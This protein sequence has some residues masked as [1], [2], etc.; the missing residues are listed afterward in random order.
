MNKQISNRQLVVRI[1]LSLLAGSIITG[2][3]FSIY[4]KNMA[5][6]NLAQEDAK[7]TSNLIFEVMRTKMQEGWG[8]E[9]LVKIMKR[10]NTMKDGL[11]IN[12]YRSSK[13]VELFGE[14]TQTTQ[15]LKSDKNIVKAMN[16]KEVLVVGDDDSIHFYYPM[17]VETECITCHYNTKEGDINGVL[18]IYFPADEI[19]IPLYAMI[20]YFILFLVI[21]LIV[22]FVVFYFILNNKI[23]LPLINFTNQLKDISNIKDMDSRIIVKTQITEIS[24]LGN[25]FNNLLDKIKYYYEKLIYQFFIDQM[26]SLPNLLALK[27]DIRE[28]NNPTLILININQFKN[29]NN[30][31]GYE[32]ED[33]ILKEFS[34][35]LAKNKS[36]SKKSYRISGDEFAWLLDEELNLFDFLETLEEFQNHP[37]EY[38]ESVIYLNISCGVAQ[39]KDRLIENATTALNQAK[40]KTKPF[41]LYDNSMQQESKINDTIYWTKKLKDALEEDRI[42]LYY[43][44]ILDVKLEKATKFE[45]LVRLK[46]KD[47]TIHSPDDFMEAAKLSRLYLR[48]TR[49]IIKQAFKYFKDKPYEFSVNVSM[50]DIS[51]L[52]T[53]N[54]I[55]NQLKNFP[56]P[57]RV[58][59]EILETE[60]ITE[61]D[62]I[63]SFAKDVKELG[64]KLAIDDF[65]SGYSNYNYIIKLNVDFL[66]I[67]SSL[68]MNIDKD[69]KIAIVVESIINSS[70]KLGLKTIAEYVSSKKIMDKVKELGVD[71][72]QGYHIDKPLVDVELHKKLLT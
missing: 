47:G 30:F 15:A 37:F 60:E 21:F 67:D 17:K 43:Q 23:V 46:D 10:L 40:I 44:P 27:K 39:S 20:T 28:Y 8:K 38:K 49:S 34:K 72:I 61:F 59:F 31:Y 32:A 25:E 41:E 68:I 2:I 5:L 51:D 6:H 13:I 64:A 4:L 54:Y 33:L 24:Q 29:I 50:E 22:I 3:I 65:G 45:S 26:T 14:D 9:D 57:S 1:T 35:L 58:V 48:L 70:H 11:E 52:A 71:F 69:E 63:N 36:I 42:V 18:D 56:E 19:S 66:K 16:G 7:K 53:K 12:A 62:L 55:L